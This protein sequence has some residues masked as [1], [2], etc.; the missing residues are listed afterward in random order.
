[1]LVDKLNYRAPD[2]CS[3]SIFL[4]CVFDHNSGR[5]LK[6]DLVIKFGSKHM[7]S[8]LQA[9]GLRKDTRL[10]LSDYQDRLKHHHR[11]RDEF[12]EARPEGLSHS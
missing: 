12:E 10:V 7:L 5:E 9:D 1:M 11:H 8:G 6:T 3:A 2:G 4:T